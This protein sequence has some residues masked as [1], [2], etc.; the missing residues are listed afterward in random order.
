MVGALD[1]VR[2]IDFGQYI[3]G[4]LAGMLLADQGADVIRVEPPGGPRFDTPANATW[5][6]GKR[7]IVLDLKQDADLETA[8]T[9]VASA[10]VVIENFRPG[11]MRRLGLDAEALVEAYPRLIAC[12]MPGFA[13]DDPRASSAAWEGVVGAA[14]A[15]YR[16]PGNPTPDRPIFTAIPIASCNAAIQGV[17]AIAIALVARE[18]DGRGQRIEVPLFDAMFAPIGGRGMIVHAPRPAAARGGGLWGGPFLCQDG[19]WVYFSAFGNTNFRE[20]IEAAGITSWDA[21]GLTDR[22]RLAGEPALAAEQAQRIRALFETRTAQEW[23]DLIAEAGSEGAV[24]RTSAEWLHHPHARESQAVV[25]VDDPVLGRMS[26][27]GVNPRLRGSLGGVRSSAPRPDADREEILAELATRTLERTSAL[28][29]PSVAETE[30]EVRAALD[31]VRVLDLCIVL[32]G[33]TAGRT[34][35]EFGADVIKIDD[36]RRKSIIYHTEINRAKRSI[37]LDLKSEA[38][39]EVF[40]RLLEDAD[41]VVQ[42]YRSGRVDALGIG[43]EAVRQRRPD[44]VYASLNAYGHE[45]PWAQRPGHEQFAQAASGMQERFGGNGAPVVQPYPIN[46]FGTGF[47]GAYAIAL[48]LRHRQRTGEGQ[49]I[50]TSLVHTAGTLQ[51][52]YL[53]D[54][55]GK[56][57]DEPRGQDSLGSSPLNRAY[58]AGDGWLFV[59]VPPSRRTAL[60][61]IDGLATGGLEGPALEARLE[62]AFANGAV[63]AWVTRLRESDIGAHR[64]VFDM[65]ELL[66][67]PWVEAHGLSVT[68]EHEGWGPI[69]T[70]GPT[71]RLSRTPVV[72]GRASPRPGSDGRAILNEIGFGDRADALVEAGVVV[73]EGVEAMVGE[74][75]R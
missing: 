2:V 69:T 70:T 34:L 13:G 36:P 64:V 28:A 63:D 40:W 32:A 31:G 1:G 41:V 22:L 39:I 62:A 26:Q 43:Y 42:N 30:G 11:V 73:T 24:C 37:L 12:S 20:F 35:G 18:R 10:D 50:D 66:T 5:N 33:P 45:G 65:R 19:R 60:D 49:H 55:R 68:R 75:L 74:P 67:D 51:S 52:L 17:V 59:A 44:I 15:A 58:R 38:G 14:S 3:A 54:F 6:R 16:T 72:P 9:L 61:G 57:W 48:A 29:A 71:Q 7:S 47:L 4:P 8:R 53:Q 25:E 56:Q 27:P 21:E 46:D 23:E